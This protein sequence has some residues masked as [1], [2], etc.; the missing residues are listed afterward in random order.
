MNALVEFDAKFEAEVRGID[1]FEAV[2]AF[3]I[4]VPAAAGKRCRAEHPNAWACTRIAGHG[5][6]HVATLWNG[7]VC[8]VWQAEP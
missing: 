8:A 4:L 1:A 6:R 2:Q 7:A 5:G 3:G